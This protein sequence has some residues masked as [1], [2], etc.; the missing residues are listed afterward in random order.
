MATI[1]NV[2]NDLIERVQDNAAN[3]RFVRIW[4]NQLDQLAD[5]DTYAFPFPNVFFEIEAPAQYNPLGQGFSVS[6]IKIR[7]HIGHEEYDAGSDL[8]EQNTNVFTLRNQIVNLFTN[9]QPSGCSSMMRVGGFPDYVHTNIYHDIVEFICSFVD[10]SGVATG[11]TEEG[12]IED[13]IFSPIDD[14]NPRA[15]IDVVANISGQ[16]NEP[17]REIEL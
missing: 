5:G 1:V 14:L 7:I 4:N 12:V 17:Y 9:F 6:D 8:L 3:F 15:N 13:I 2:Y 10:D 11:G 16:P